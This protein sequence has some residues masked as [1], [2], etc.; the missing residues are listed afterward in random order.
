MLPERKIN[1]NKNGDIRDIISM[2]IG[3]YWYERQTWFIVFPVMAEKEVPWGGHG[4]RPGLLQQP[5]KKLG[6]RG[7]VWP[8]YDQ[9]STLLWS[10]T[11]PLFRAWHFIYVTS[12]HWPLARVCPLCPHGLTFLLL[13]TASRG[14]WLSGR[15]TFYLYLR[16]GPHII[17]HLHTNK[18]SFCKIKV[19]DRVLKINW[20][21]GA[22]LGLDLFQKSIF[23]FFEIYWFWDIASCFGLTVEC[24]YV[25][26]SLE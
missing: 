9:L 16:R 26:T 13:P 2:E 3:Y 24:S 17:A 11:Q 19:T 22:W 20:G 7:H 12:R 18:E 1:L 21:G 8:L 25:W 6:M 14:G 4:Q 5:T 23:L 15:G 10:I